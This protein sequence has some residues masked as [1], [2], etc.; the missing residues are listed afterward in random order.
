M[1]PDVALGFDVGT[2][3]VKAGLLWLD[4]DGPPETVS[5]PYPT[6]RP[7]PGWVEQDPGAWLSAMRSCWVELTA[8]AGPIRLRSVGLCSQINTHLLVDE[9]LAPMYPAINWQDTRAVAEAAELDALVEG[10]REEFWGGPFTIDASYSLSRL[11]WLSRHEPA[12]FRA[13][14]WMLSPKDYCVALLTGEVVTDTIS[15]VGLVGAD[16]HYI[17]GALALVEGAE[18]LMP[19]LHAFDSQAGSTRPS[20]PAGLPSGVPVAVGTMDAWGSVFGSGLIHR[21]QAMEVSGAS[22]IMAVV[23]DRTVPTNGIIS[24]A[25]VHGRYLHAGPTQAGGSALDW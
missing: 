6:G 23:S 19:P 1:V 15:P 10:R 9:A 12:A 25:P 17:A 4:D 7:R 22:E 11:L 21:G 14:C 3:S 20:N 13:A 8:R 16:D 5:H 18:A 2:T 24:F